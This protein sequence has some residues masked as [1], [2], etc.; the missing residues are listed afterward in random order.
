MLEYASS[1]FRAC[2]CCDRNFVVDGAHEFDVGINGKRGKRTNNA[3][4]PSANSNFGANAGGI[5]HCQC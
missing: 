1:V 2:N 3:I 5:S 4:V